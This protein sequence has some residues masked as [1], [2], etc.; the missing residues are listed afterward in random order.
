VFSVATIATI[1]LGI[2]AGCA[3]FGLVNAVLLRPLPYRDSERLVGVWHAMPGLGIAAAKLSPGTYTIYRE[4]AKSF[5]EM[6]VYVSLAAT[7]TYR[8]PDRAPE[9]VRAAYMT[10]STFSV[11]GARP[12][13]GRLFTDADAAKGATPVAVIS[14]RL[15]KTR[16]GGDQRVT[17]QSIDVDGGSRRIIGVMPE[18]FAFP[19]AQS[20]VWLPIDV[21]H[22]P[23]VGGFGYDGI[24]RLRSGV[25][26]EAA[27]RELEQIL[28]RLPERY[29]EMRPGVSTAVGLR[30]TGLAPV[31]HLMRND[32]I[33][34]FERVLW[35]IAGTVALLVIVAFSNVASLMLVRVEARQRE[36]AVRS[37]LGASKF[38]VWQ[39]VMAETAVVAAIGGALGVG[40]AA[41]ALR[42]LVGLGPL[43]L[44]RVNEVRLDADGVMAAV[45]LT[46]V[47]ALVS[48][49][50]GALRIRSGDTARILRDGGR[51]GT[52]G[53]ASQRV[54]SLFVAVEVAL[55][56]VLLAGSAVLGR[57][58]LRLRAVQPGFDPSNTFTFWT[59]LP[60]TSYKRAPDAARFYREA[61]DRIGR[62]PGVVAVGATAKLPLEI[63]GFPYKVLI[64]ADDGA[65]PS[66]ALPPVFQATTATSGYF[67][68]MRIPLLAGRSFDDA[69]ITRGA[70]EAVASRGFVEHF[71]HDATGRSGVGKRVRP[72]ANGPW[73]TIVGVV[74]DVRDSALTESPI[75]EV[76]FPQ[77]ASAADTSGATS[78][79]AR[80]MAFVV[81]TRGP[82]PGLSSALRRELNALDP[83]LPFY[84]PASMD[85]VIEDARGRMTFALLLLAVGA[86]TT[87]LLGIVGLY[88]VIAYVVS[89]RSREISIRIALG[90]APTGAA[91][92]IL[93]QGETI[94]A[95]GASVGIALFVVFSK[96]LESLAF[97]VKTLDVLTL[98]GA[99]VAVI[100]VATLATW[101]PARRAA[102]VNPAHALKA[103]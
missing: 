97:E 36:F 84:R 10:A 56:L 99:V 12:L 102:A 21:T 49:V 83:N 42:L 80:D 44:P 26:I 20:P 72:N 11:L 54:R 100:V 74:G 27:Q 75:S 58:L 40:L 31:I 2:G 88:G 5:E 66:N 1:A 15:W 79:T 8:I 92:M 87:L 7:L 32:V 6:G 50:I 51:A 9:R 16:F 81:R 77:E 91:R 95:L 67:D 46:S 14:E 60:V 96:L 76:Y 45:A 35:L 64:W 17:E 53:R 101:V 29:P 103:D 89:L 86:G 78:Q 13:L 43:D 62:L 23:Y 65:P 85:R 61:I 34:G 47:F 25:P 22:Q 39:S 59:F 24:G 4:G 73:F 3:V 57:S 70:L 52:S 28:I 38:G 37:A 48:A 90:L 18:R 68:A 93:R 55:S 69:G 82:A 41:I 94:V 33:A 63:E 19:A 30:Q 98:A 71:W